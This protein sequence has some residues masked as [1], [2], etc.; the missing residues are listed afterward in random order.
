DVRVRLA[1]RAPTR[2][3]VD[4]ALAEFAAIAAFGPAGAGGVRQSAHPE[5]RVSIAAIPAA[6][7]TARASLLEADA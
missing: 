6:L 7:T 3:A 1:T 2:D 4:A 5:R